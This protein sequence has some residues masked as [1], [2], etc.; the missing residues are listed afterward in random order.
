MKKQVC[1]QVFCLI[2]LVLSISH[3]LLAQPDLARGFSS[4]KWLIFPDLQQKDRFY[5]RPGKMRLATTPDGKPDAVFLLMRQTGSAADGRDNQLHYNSLF[6]CRVLLEN[7]GADGLQLIL[8]KLRS[9]WPGQDLRLE[10]LPIWKTAVQLVVPT[11]EGPDKNY[12]GNLENSESDAAGDYW[13]ERLFT[14]KLG[15]FDAQLLEKALSIGQSTLNLQYTFFSKGTAPSNATELQ[16]LEQT[17]TGDSTVSNLT[18]TLE[19]DTQ[20]SLQPVFSDALMLA[21]DTRKYPDLIRKI[22]INAQA[23]PGY[24]LLEVRCY[25]FNNALRNDLFAKRI[26]VEAEGVGGQKVKAKRTFYAAQPDVYVQSLRFPFAVKLDRPLRY[27][28]TELSEERAPF[29]S[30]WVVWKNWNAM[31][32]ITKN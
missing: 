10:P 17:D 13:S 21:L 32:D 28:V 9:E 15:N 30:A 26:E 27:R 29:S 8:E 14:V 1:L 16:K 12:I 4:E 22:D 18:T 23:P 25:D 19:R 24:A 5:Y 6:Q 7:P 3:S 31:I 2:Q 20:I 11:V